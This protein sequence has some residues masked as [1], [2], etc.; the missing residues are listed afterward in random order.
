MKYIIRIPEPCNEKWSE[1]TPTERGRYCKV[2]Q[3]EIYDFTQMSNFD[4]VRKLDKGENVCGRFKKSQLD[5]ELDSLKDVSYLGRIALF[6]GLTSLVSVATQTVYAKPVAN[7]PVQLSETITKSQKKEQVSDKNE[8]I[9]TI[10]GRVFAYSVS[11][12]NSL[13]GVNISYANNLRRIL[14]TTNINGEF[15]VEIPEKEFMENVELCFWTQEFDSYNCLVE[16]DVEYFE[17]IMINNFEF[18][19]PGFIGKVEVT[20]TRSISLKYFTNLF[21]KKRKK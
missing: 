9:V 10:R 20:T 12:D 19:D 15:C 4:L 18:K 17:V 13:L 3:K 8:N 11:D 14:A 1:M 16:K 6:F 5:V 2:C 7:T 21:R